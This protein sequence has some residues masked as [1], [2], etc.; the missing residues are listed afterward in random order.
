MDSRRS[1][2]DNLNAGRQRRPQTSLDQLTRSLSK[3]EQQ[4]DQ[5]A[6]G[7]TERP[8][9]RQDRERLANE[10]AT[11]R[12]PASQQSNRYYDDG[13]SGRDDGRSNRAYDD[14]RTSRPRADAD[15]LAGELDALR[16]EMKALLGETRGARTAQSRTQSDSNE[17]KSEIERLTAAVQ[18]MARRSDDKG[19]NALRLELEQARA[20]IELLAREETVRSIGQRW[21]DFEERFTARQSVGASGDYATLAER[22]DD[23]HAALDRLPE[24][25]PLRAIDDKFRTLS[26]AV[27][28]LI[29]QRAPVGYD[30][31]PMRR[32]EDRMDEIARAIQSASHAPAAFDDG[33]LVRLERRLDDISR[34]IANVGG[35]TMDDSSVERLES[36]IAA[37]SRQIEDQIA[38]PVAHP[39]FDQDRL[40]D[41]IES[42]LDELQARFEADRP[43]RAMQGIEQ[44][45][46]DLASRLDKP[47]RSAAG[48]DPLAVS[49]LE[50]QI[51][52]LST[53]L[54]RPDTMGGPNDELAPRLDRLERSIQES[55]D[56]VVTAASQAAEQAVRRLGSTQGPDS[57]VANGL[58]SDLRDLETL[59]RKSDERN[60]KTFEAIHDT[61]LKIVDRLGTIEQTDQAKPVEFGRKS[62]ETP[63]IAP[64]ADF[65]PVE[66]YV[67]APERT[68]MT[69]A[70]AAAAAAMAALD[71]PTEQ[72]VAKRSMLGGLTRKLGRKEQEPAILA[73]SSVSVAAPSVELDE[74]LDPKAVNRPLEPGSGAPDLNA[75]MRRVRDERAGP[76]RVENADAAKAD[77]IAAARRAAQ[78]AAAEAEVLKAK[79]DRAA[80]GGKSGLMNLLTARRKP[81]LMA[82]VA[83][84]IAL[85]GIQLSRTMVSDPAEISTESQTPKPLS[86]NQAEPQGAPET[87]GEETPAVRM[88]EANPKP[89][90]IEAAPVEAA[91]AEAAPAET[92]STKAPAAEEGP[93]TPLSDEQA[94]AMEAEPEA[95]TQV[96]AAAPADAAAEPAAAATGDIPVDAGPI[97]LREAAAGGDSKALFEIGARYSDGRGVKSDMKEAAKWYEKSAELGFAPA[98]YR[99]GN[100]YEK[101]N[102]VER[103]VKKAKTWYQLAANQGNASAM[104][105][106]AVL[107]AMGTDGTPDNESAVRW[108]TQA[109]DYGVKDSQ[110]NLGILAAKGVGMTQNLEES[111]KWFGLVA[112]TGDRDASTKRDEIAKSLRPEQLQ[113][114]RASVELW[115]AKEPNAEANSADIPESWQESPGQ[116]ASVDQAQSVDMKKAIRNVQGILNKNG[117]DAGAADGVMG[118]RTKLAIRAFQKD[119]G[120]DPTGNVD[121]AL[122]EALLAKN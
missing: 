114:A 53:Y 76:G 71:E 63:S 49:N 37:L 110:F 14:N 41:A 86:Q 94:A 17:I 18:G 113:R 26:T 47:Q 52:N 112:K 102:G 11:Y 44:R 60:S 30:D 34:S 3:L 61:L 25:L 10:A 46:D 16:G 73:G 117:Y 108:F 45:L 19:V 39:S 109:A 88:A 70:Q 33:S 51:A 119:N 92:A 4:L 23:M 5:H 31:E 28:S 24:S 1:Y 59:T 35:S 93:D 40:V 84:M 55:R 15:Q 106:L 104:H 13:R 20:T 107:F 91:P 78:A 22:I 8:I 99:I 79:S 69:P 96:V 42:R 32:L 48:M 81:I 43:T 62:V 85:A 115:K 67:P 57:E 95:D 75:I 98:Q 116:T 121:K 118:E 54:S 9:Y 82:A 89:A 65:E 21:D 36:R 77:F 83:V 6:V 38:R 68:P 27:E 12:A 122:V 2:L 56:L 66:A 72:P 50:A 120:L 90:P 74:P 103:D 97:P 64:D 100:F 87:A 29:N 58:V 111:Y 105:N 7:R 80:P 101:G